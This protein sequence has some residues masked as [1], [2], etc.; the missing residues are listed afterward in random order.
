[1][2]IF[3]RGVK[4]GKFD[5]RTGLS[6]QRAQGILGQI[7]II[8]PK[9]QTKRPMG[10]VDAIRTIVGKG[11]GF[12]MPCN[13]KVTFEC[14]L[15]IQQPKRTEGPPGPPGGGFG[16]PYT[17]GE[18]SGSTVKGGSL[19]WKSHQLN[20]STSSQIKSLFDE[21]NPIAVTNYQPFLTTTKETPIGKFF[22]E[23]SG[24]T[25]PNGGGRRAVR[26]LDLYCSKVSIPEKTINIGQYRHYGEPFPF[27]QSIQYGTLT[28]TFYCDAVMTIKRFFDGWQKL[29][30]NDITGNFNY[31]DEYVSNFNIFTRS[32]ISAAAA[33]KA[34]SAKESDTK[35]FPENLSS[36]IKDA[37]KAFNELTGVPG[38]P[39]TG[40]GNGKVP[41]V[42][43]ADTY[44]V[45]VFNCWPQTVG[46]VDLAHDATD[47]IGTFDVTWAYTKWSP[48]KMGEI[49]N[50][51]EVNLSI[52]E[53]RNEKD[54]FP[55][56]EDLPP[57]LSGPLTGAL[58]QA[59]TTGPLS[60]LSNLV[61]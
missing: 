43:F 26:K 17:R 42:A 35:S 37:T 11:E 49:G 22:G 54:G 9:P 53:F 5:V 10:E 18:R 33:E 32:T 47:Q 16:A 2:A 55:F 1:M 24:D 51:S 34:V 31:Y 52:G 45:K 50:R 39:E 21:A 3:Q 20:R 56:L 25:G 59:V 13:F 6:K 40:D 48:F 8:P 61:G 27:P 41:A 19:D 12:M 46:S 7:G 4:V 15:G 58:G 60:N 36:M 29:I 23:A 28:T 57:E 14:P 30:I 38:P 44:G